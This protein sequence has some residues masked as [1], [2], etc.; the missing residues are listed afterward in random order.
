MA[1]TPRVDVVSSVELGLTDQQMVVVVRFLARLW[2][3]IVRGYRPVAVLRRYTSWQLF[4]RLVVAPPD[5]RA[6]RPPTFDDVAAVTVCRVAE[7]HAFATANVRTRPPRWDALLFE[8]RA[9]PAGRGHVVDLRQLVDA[10]DST[11]HAVHEPADACDEDEV[12][13]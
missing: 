6:M 1:A 13:G 8:L 7:Q 10:R 11:G 3:D 12:D 4:G 9:D 2:I 5:P